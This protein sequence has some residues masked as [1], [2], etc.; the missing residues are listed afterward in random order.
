MQTILCLY[1]KVSYYFSNN[2]LINSFHVVYHRVINDFPRINLYNCLIFFAKCSDT[3]ICS[4]SIS[5]YSAPWSLFRRC[6]IQPKGKRQV[7]SLF[8][9]SQPVLVRRF[10]L[11]K[12]TG[13]L[14]L[15]PASGKIEEKGSFFVYTKGGYLALEFHPIGE[16]TA[17]VNIQRIIKMQG[18]KYT[19]E[20]KKTY[21]LTTK[22][23]GALLKLNPDN[24]GKSKPL[25]LTQKTKAQGDLTKVVNV[26]PVEEDYVEF[27]YSEKKGEKTEE[28]LTIKIDSN[29]LLVMQKMIE[30]AMPYIY[31]WQHLNNPQEV[32]SAASRAD[33]AQYHI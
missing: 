17:T 25:E 4:V 24:L 3:V 16:G 14:S 20:N 26:K 9:K 28:P 30:Y 10:T 7:L 18:P 29:E 12:S 19:Y 2:Q 21:F 6:L 5:Q 32:P 22:E 27:S 31:G 1:Q 11:P 13:M 23:I 15:Y 33:I 8:T